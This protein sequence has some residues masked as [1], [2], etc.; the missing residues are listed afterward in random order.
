MTI[1]EDIKKLKSGIKKIGFIITFKR[2]EFEPFKISF[3]P[4][5]FHNKRFQTLFKDRL[6]RSRATCS[7]N[8]KAENKYFV[9][10]FIVILSWELIRKINLSFLDKILKSV[11]LWP[12]ES[13][14]FFLNTVNIGQREMNLISVSTSCVKNRETVLN[15]IMKLFNSIK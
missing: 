13:Y 14:N 5:A 10:Q 12:M 7:F 4:Y 6:D 1:E 15:I 8:L 11:S 3:L 9:T 2:D